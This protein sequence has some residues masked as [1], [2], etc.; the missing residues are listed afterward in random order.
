MAQGGGVGYYDNEGGGGHGD[1]GGD[2]IQRK[3]KEK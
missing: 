1:G 2:V 3:M